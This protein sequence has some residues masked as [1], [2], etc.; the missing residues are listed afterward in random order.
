MRPLA[1]ATIWERMRRVADRFIHHPITEI[2]VVILILCWVAA[3]V[4]EHTI[5]DPAAQVVL[6]WFGQALS[7]IFVIEL[8]IRFWVAPVKRHF[9]RD[10]Y[11]D[12]IAVMPFS[13][14]RP[15]RL[16]RLLRVGALIRRSAGEVAIVAML[17]LCFV[18]GAAMLLDAHHAA[19][20]LTEGEELASIWFSLFTF[21]GGEPIGGYPE[22]DEGR[23]ITLALMVGCMTLFGMFIG[24]VSASMTTAFSQRF[25]AS[26]MERIDHMRGHL[27]VC[28]WN[29]A[30]PVMLK[31]L[32]T[33]RDQPQHVVVITEHA[34]RPKDLAIEGVRNEQIHYVSGDYTKIEV[35]E[36]ANISHCAMAIL[37]TDT[38]IPRSDQDRDARTVLAALTIERLNPEVFCCAELT[39]WEHAELLRR[40]GVEEIVVRDWYAGVILGSMS[41]NW[42]LAAV[43]RDIL[44]TSHGNA[45]NKVLVRSQEA[46]QT[47]GDLHSSLKMS[48]GLILVALEHNK[49]DGARTITVNPSADTV[50]Q[51]GDVMVVIGPNA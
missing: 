21:V 18:L 47:I 6:I 46:G 26:N 36:K 24:A 11:L 5:T 3:L 50:V 34:D 19:V 44:S 4:G 33:T 51:T 16:L 49:P 29:L 12:I 23:L 25:E 14:V 42:G 37:L 31:E 43:L 30:G 38:L 32:F 39:S 2:F 41:R 45:F 35:L 17:S 15:L 27:V 1:P 10:Y 20:N 7:A 13:L 9:F 48:R 40:S 22:T 8:L 28:G